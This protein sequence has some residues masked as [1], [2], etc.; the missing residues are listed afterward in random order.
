[1]NM[2]M[3]SALCTGV[4]H[5]DVPLQS[6]RESSSLGDIDWH[7]GSVLGL[8]GINIVGRHRLELGVEGMDLLAARLPRPVE[9]GGGSDPRL[10]L[11][12]VKQVS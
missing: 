6:L 8:S 1:M 5:A 10:L 3:S 9:G 4:G 7:P 11:V 2:D 12:A